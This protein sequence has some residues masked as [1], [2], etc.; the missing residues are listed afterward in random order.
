[1]TLEHLVSTYKRHLSELCLTH[2]TYHTASPGERDR[3]NYIERTFQSYGLKT[4][5]ETY[6][7]RGW[8]FHSFSFYDITAGKDVPFAT[9]QYF[10]GCANFEGKL[11]IVTPSQVSEIETF[12]VQDQ[13]IF[14]TGDL[15]TFENGDIAEKL[16]ELGAVGV[17][18]A[19][20]DP[21]V[22]YPHTKISRSPYINNIG[23]CVVA[24]LGAAYLSANLDH[25][26]RFTVDAT[27]YDAVSDNVVAYVEGDDTKVVFG[28][29]YDSAPLLQGAGDNASGTAMLLEL[30]RLMKDRSCGHTLEFVA[31]TAEEYCE[32]PPAKGAK[33]SNAYL[34][35]HAGE[36][37][38]CFINIDDYCASPLFAETVLGVGH[39][40]K[41]PEIDWPLLPNAP[42]LCSDDVPFYHRG[43][44]VVFIAQ[45]KK[46]NV[47]H[48]V[49][50]TI[51]FIDFDAM[52]DITP[53]YVSIATQLLEKLSEGM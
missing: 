34:D 4:R 51:D 14:L 5:R 11:L 42:I 16:E 26:Y 13:L 32:R 22:G 20:T 9:C 18:Y 39:P 43:I 44:P 6:P 31:F 37:I 7:V 2:L 24:P 41:L 8:E 50:D 53:A 17:V 10:S 48:S 1:M 15:G 52:A 23:T 30:A 40:E 28:A 12:D 19:Q 25:V 38:A 36:K 33:G 47:V 21:F 45:R 3:A 46:I 27:P 29:H 49:Q 35:R